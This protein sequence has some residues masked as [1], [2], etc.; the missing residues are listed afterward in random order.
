MLAH[1]AKSTG[2]SCT[3]RTRSNASTVRSSGA[4]TS[5]R[6]SPTRAPSSDS[7]ARCCSNDEW[8][9]SRARYMSLEKLAAISDDPQARPRRGRGGLKGG[10]SP[11]RAQ[12]MTGTLTP[13]AGTRSRFPHWEGHP[14][15]RGG[16]RLCMGSLVGRRTRKGVPDLFLGCRRVGARWEH[17][18]AASR[19]QLT[20]LVCRFAARGNAPSREVAEWHRA[21]GPA[22]QAS[23][24][25]AA[26]AVRRQ[27]KGAACIRPALEN[28]RC[29]NHGGLSTG[30]RTKSGRKRIAAAQRKRWAEWRG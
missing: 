10:P 18:G 28:G 3:P 19:P 13:Q 23:S 1:L 16:P 20:R 17:A 7:S 22:E 5:S 2:R 26:A 30:P 29:P 6:S 11:H 14:P 8:A 27:R 21:R 24:Q 4:R 15:P 25:R 9:A 12:T